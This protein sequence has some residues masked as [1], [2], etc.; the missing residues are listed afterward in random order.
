MPTTLRFLRVNGQPLVGREVFLLTLLVIG[1]S[2]F[3]SNSSLIF[4]SLFFSKFSSLASPCIPMMLLLP[5]LMTTRLGP[6]GSVTKKHW[7]TWLPST[8]GSF[9]TDVFF[10]MA[11]GIPMVVKYQPYFSMF[12]A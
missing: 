10:D 3:F 4:G 7:S 9:F 1:M 2:K 6:D 12:L 8:H 5:L 11:S